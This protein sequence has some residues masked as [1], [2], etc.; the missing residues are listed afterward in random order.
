MVVTLWARRGKLAL[1]PRPARGTS[2]EDDSPLPGRDIHTRC[3]SLCLLIGKLRLRRMNAPTQ[4][5][6]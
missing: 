6:W 3:L 5:K 4:L 1:R 2:P